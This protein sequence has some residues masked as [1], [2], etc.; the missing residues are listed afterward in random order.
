MDKMGPHVRS[1]HQKLTFN[2][3]NRLR[4]PT[5]QRPAVA[6]GLLGQ[7]RFGLTRGSA[8]PWWLQ[9]RLALHVDVQDALSMTVVRV[10]WTLR[11]ATTVI[12]AL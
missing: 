4:D 3:H 8:E 6:G 5:C 7:P 9:L 1:N 11:I 2:C 10:K 12:P